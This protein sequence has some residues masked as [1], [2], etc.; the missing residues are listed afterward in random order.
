MSEPIN[1]ATPLPSTADTE[2]LRILSVFHYALGGMVAFFGSFPLIH[3]TVG[4][5]LIFGVIPTPG[6][7]PNANRFAGVFFV[8]IGGILVLLA[9]TMAILLILS[10]RYMATRRRQMFSIVVAGI[11]CAFFPFGTVL[12]VF[13]FIVLLRPSV[14]MLYGI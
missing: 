14:K 7:Q 5:L 8:V 6:A 1:Y 9:W 4:L 11:S 2:H 3:V 10:G 13:T 12:G